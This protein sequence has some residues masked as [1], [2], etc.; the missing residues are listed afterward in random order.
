LLADAQ[1]RDDGVRDHEVERII[2]KTVYRRIDEAINA[3]LVPI[4]DNSVSSR[5]ITSMTWKRAMSTPSRRAKAK[6]AAEEARIKGQ[7]AQ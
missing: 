4:I 2:E 6:V 5:T 1:P 3:R 7:A